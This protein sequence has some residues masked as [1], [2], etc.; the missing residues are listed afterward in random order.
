MN[1]AEHSIPSDNRLLGSHIS[2]WEHS[3]EED[4]HWSV[5]N[6]DYPDR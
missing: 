4:D 6:R 3:C 5:W 2:D 1:L